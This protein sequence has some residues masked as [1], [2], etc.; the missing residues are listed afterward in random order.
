VSYAATEAGNN[1]DVLE[2]YHFQHP[3]ES[4][5]LTSGDRAFVYQSRQYDPAIISRSAPEMT[6]D[7][8]GK[9]TVRVERTNPAALWF[10]V[11][12]PHST[13]W[14]DIYRTHLSDPDAEV[15]LYWSGR[16]RSV[17]WSG[18]EAALD[19]EPAGAV[20]LRDGLRYTYQSLCNH[21]LYG[22]GCKVNSLAYQVAVAPAGVSGTD[23]VTL[24]A[25]EFASQPD[26]YWTGGFIARNF[27]DQRLITSHAANQ[28]TISMPFEDWQPT[29]VVHIYPGCD[30]TRATCKTK[31]GNLDNYFGF[32]DIP[33]RNPFEAGADGG[34]QSVGIVTS[35]G[36]LTGGS[37]V[38]K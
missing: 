1:G 34:A 19:C 28:I 29:D 13:V 2:L 30:H 35:G 9:I 23:G 36:G 24:T 7:G 37:G 31:F 21:V 33:R 3:L 14:L 38:V 27:D 12:V 6:G 5:Y 26:G 4:Q 32:A 10:R 25:P 15:V 11:I 22:P 8:Q 18:Q 17:S 20:L 16:V